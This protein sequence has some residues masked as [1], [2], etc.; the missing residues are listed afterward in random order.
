M[1][2][3]GGFLRLK[4]DDTFVCKISHSH[5]A[6]Q[7]NMNEII[8]FDVNTNPALPGVNIILMHVP[9][10]PKICHLTLLP[11]TNKNVPRC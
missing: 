2:K 1:H 11:F 10:H 3:K 5:F 6:V 7:D 9:R 4:H 8:E